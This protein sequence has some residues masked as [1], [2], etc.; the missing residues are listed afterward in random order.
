MAEDVRF[1]VEGFREIWPLKKKTKFIG[2]RFQIC[3]ILF[4]GILWLL[5]D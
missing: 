1:G 3:S 2:P 5:G 4:Y